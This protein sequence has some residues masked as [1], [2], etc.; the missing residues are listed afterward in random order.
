MFVSTAM[1]P[2]IATE[3]IGAVVLPKAPTP[4]V[5]F[6]IGFALPYLESGVSA[7]VQRAMPMLTQ[8]GVVDANGKVDLDRAKQA[9]QTALE[10]AGG[11]VTVGGYVV[12]ASDIDA[13]FSI[14]EKHATVE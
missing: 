10:R 9:A 8:F 12:D 13:L 5:Q 4:L 7:Q 6:G 2:Q 3:F 11:K 14:A 1:L